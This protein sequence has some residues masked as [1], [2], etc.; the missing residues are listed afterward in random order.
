MTSMILG[1]AGQSADSTAQVDRIVRALQI[2]R[3]VVLE[4]VPGTGKTYTVAAVRD[5]WNALAQKNPRAFS[6]IRETYFRT[7]HP[8]TT[9][10]DFI[11]GLQPQDGG[12]SW[13]SGFFK[14]AC[15]HAERRPEEDVLV[16]LDEF[17]RC[18]V[19]KVMGDLLTILEPSKRLRRGKSGTGWD[20]KTGTAVK[21][22][23]Q[24]DFKVPENVLVI[25]TMNTTDRSVAPLDA[26]LR[27]RFA[28]QR[29]WPLG[30]DPA[31]KLAAEGVAAEIWGTEPAD[32]HFFTQSVEAWSQVNVGLRKFGNDT[33][34]GHSYLHALAD[35]LRA[36]SQVVNALGLKG[37][38]VVLHHWNHHILPALSESL[39]SNRLARKIDVEK[40]LRGIQV[41]KFGIE[42]R[43]AEAEK[44][45]LHPPVL[46]LA[47]G[48]A[49]E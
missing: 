43:R 44:D 26:A 30:F 33:M 46:K 11:G 15:E 28:F 39:M 7:M 48:A 10:E 41:A 29:L 13:T 37:P 19:P 5:A 21:L 17:N 38:D 3:N 1:D 35:D 4:G 49:D 16:V 2:S 42:D 45:N 32:S 31:V 47:I 23:N 25:A 12:F 9:Y 34:L 8:A 6:P 36:D 27:R 24:A 40:V 18:N 14:E 20:A 22:T